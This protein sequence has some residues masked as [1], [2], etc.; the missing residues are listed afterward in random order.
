MS[1][2]KVRIGVTMVTWGGGV[3]F[4][5]CSGGTLTSTNM[6]EMHKKTLYFCGG[7]QSANSDPRKYLNQL[8]YV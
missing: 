2:S 3:S 5:C 8:K 7:G 6:F 1:G 4:P